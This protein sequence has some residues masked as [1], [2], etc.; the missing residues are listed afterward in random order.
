MA[1]SHVLIAI[2]VVQDFI[3][4][5]FGSSDT[6]SRVSTCEQNEEKW[7]K[8][9]DASWEQWNQLNQLPGKLEHINRNMSKI[10]SDLDRITEEMRTV[11]AKL[12][13]DRKIEEK[14]WIAVRTLQHHVSTN[15]EGTCRD[16]ALRH[17]IKL[18]HTADKLIDDDSDVIRI[19]ASIHQTIKDALGEEKAAA[20]EREKV[21]LAEPEDVDL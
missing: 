5:L 10:L 17:V 12:G 4:Q 2:D 19:K 14:C 8:V 3:Y 11:Y 7:H 1:N 20:L 9:A 13:E 16:D 15:G 6:D 18:T 21:H